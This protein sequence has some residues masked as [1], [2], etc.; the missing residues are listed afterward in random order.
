LHKSGHIP[1]S[2]SSHEQTTKEIFPASHEVLLMF[3]PLQNQLTDH[4][5]TCS[6]FELE[7]VIVTTKKISSNE[8]TLYRFRYSGSYRILN[9]PLVAIQQLVCD[10]EEFCVFHGTQNAVRICR[11]LIMVDIPLNTPP[12]SMGWTL[13]TS[14]ALCL[15]Y[16]TTLGLNPQ[17][18]LAPILAEGVRND[19]WQRLDEMIDIFGRR[20]N[21]W[22]LINS[23][24]QSII[25]LALEYNVYE[26]FNLFL[27]INL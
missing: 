15:Q 19:R 4:H 27:S 9:D 5:N 11:R 21:N 1:L 13:A 14:L 25:K 2:H 24:C 3:I 8:K 10:N 7:N 17:E 6:S 26:I 12:S 16:M 23:L 20:L 18:L 22:P